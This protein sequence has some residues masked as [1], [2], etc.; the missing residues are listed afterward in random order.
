MERVASGKKV[1]LRYRLKDGDGALLADNL[2]DGPPQTYL[3]G[4]RRMIPGLES[5]LHGRAAGERLSLRIPPEEAYG[6]RPDPVMLEHRDLGER[7]ATVRVGD[8]LDLRVGERDHSLTVIAMDDR[9][10][11][12]D[13]REAPFAGVGKTLDFETLEV[14]AIEEASPTELKEAGL[15]FPN[16][17]L[18]HSRMPGPD[19]ELIAS[20]RHLSMTPPF[21]W[22]QRLYGRLFESLAAALPGDVIELGVG[23]GGMSL[24]LG[25]L[26]ERAGKHLFAYDSFSGLPPPDPVAD[27]PYFVAGDYAANATYGDLFTRFRAAIDRF[28]LSDTIIPVSGYFAE[29]LRRISSEQRFCFAHLDSDLYASIR[30][31]LEAIWDRVPDGG[32]IVIDDFFHHSMGPQRAAGDFFNEQEIQ[33]VYHVSFP[34]SVFVVKGEAADRSAPRSLDGKWYSFDWLRS[35]DYFKQ[36]IRESVRL[37]ER[38]EPSAFLDAKSFLEILERSDYRS[39]DIYVYWKALASFWDSLSGPDLGA[40]APLRI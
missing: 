15:Y 16:D 9:F 13:R 20:L 8:R 36:T 21:P 26:A 12:L 23:L 18:Q 32:V 5:A 39:S 4:A 24:F 19:G 7:A 25:K 29:T 1:S 14:V 35:D 17:V 38:V 31:S 37:S 34:Y 6:A 3:H 11:Y 22:G 2:T 30:L 27:N 28:D 10:V 40:R 33:P